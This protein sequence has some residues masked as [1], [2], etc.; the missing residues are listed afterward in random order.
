MPTWQIH[1]VAHDFGDA[2]VELKGRARA[3]ADFAVILDFQ[4]RR[5]RAVHAVDIANGL[6][7]QQLH[8]LRFS[9]SSSANYLTVRAT[10]ENNFSRVP[11]QLLRTL[12]HARTIY[13]H[14]LPGNGADTWA[15]KLV[16]TSIAFLQLQNCCSSHYASQNPSTSALQY[17]L[18]L[19][20]PLPLSDAE[21]SVHQP[22]LDVMQ[23]STETE[24]RARVQDL[25][26]VVREEVIRGRTENLSG[27]AQ[28]SVAGAKPRSSGTGKM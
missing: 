11:H 16:D 22:V 25:L 12:D 6:R 18:R 7:N 15:M 19:V 13:T 24:M 8:K 2:R 21:A 9:S 23:R 4:N 3:R 27:R 5:R 17:L 14:L 1:R 10:A 26:C 20:V 28:E